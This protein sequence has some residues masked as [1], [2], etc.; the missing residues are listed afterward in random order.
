MVWVAPSF[1]E[2]SR[3]ALDWLNERTDAGVDFFG[4]EVSVV[5]I[6]DDGPRAPVFEVVARPNGWQKSVKAATR[7]GTRVTGPTLNQRR[8]DFFQEVLTALAEQRP[9]VRVPKPNRDSWV[10]YASGPFGHWTS[11]SRGTAG[12]VSRCTSTAVTQTGT[13]PC[14]TGCTRNAT[15]GSDACGHPIS[16]ERPDDRR[17]CRIASYQDVSN[18]RRRPASARGR[19]GRGRPRPR[20]VRLPQRRTPK[21]G[22][23]PEGGPVTGPRLLSRV[24]VA[25]A[26]RAG[27]QIDRRRVDACGGAV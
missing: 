27:G 24:C 22:T 6:G 12:C 25:R 5:Q 8:Q 4:V 18:D 20:D 21:Q 3:R 23:R 1:R 15:G 26:A 2:E 14:S 10:S 13:R 9:R 16:W 7:Q 19:R 17:A 11:R